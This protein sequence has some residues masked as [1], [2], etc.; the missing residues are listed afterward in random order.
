MPRGRCG[1]SLSI[2]LGVGSAPCLFDVDSDG[3]GWT[4]VEGDCNDD[5]AT[6]YP[7]AFE[8]LDDGVDQDCDG[9]DAVAGCT[10]VAATNFAPWAN[11]PDGSCCMR[12]R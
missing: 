8:T 3:D 5:D 7:G 12:F 4:D 11:V 6:T 1:E 2:A 9:M 10:D